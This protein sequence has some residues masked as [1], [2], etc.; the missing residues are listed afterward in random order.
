MLITN[1]R[2]L[3]GRLRAFE[4]VD[5]RLLAEMNLG[6]IKLIRLDNIERFIRKVNIILF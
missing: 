1:D 5:V 2:G 4:L 3:H 6:D